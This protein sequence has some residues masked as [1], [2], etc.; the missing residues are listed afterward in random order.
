MASELRTLVCKGKDHE[1]ILVY[2]IK[3]FNFDISEYF[4]GKKSLSRFLHDKEIVLEK[5]SYSN[6]SFIKIMA[7]HSGEY[8]HVRK[9]TDSRFILGNQLQINGV[10]L[11]NKQLLCIAKDILHIS[12][13]FIEYANRLTKSEFKEIE[14]AYNK[15]VKQ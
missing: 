12:R 8:I 5:K 1:D 9:D 15:S 7:A 2:L 4:K 13:A 3:L 6:L 14:D 11:L 10:S